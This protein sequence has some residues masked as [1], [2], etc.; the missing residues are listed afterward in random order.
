MK[1]Q[2]KCETVSLLEEHKLRVY[3]GGGGREEHLDLRG[4]VQQD[5]TIKFLTCSTVL[6]IQN[7]VCS[8]TLFSFICRYSCFDTE[9]LHYIY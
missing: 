7:N 5:A 8:Y 2:T 6:L 9:F 4:G 3:W 1:I